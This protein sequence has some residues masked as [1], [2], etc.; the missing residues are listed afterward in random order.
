MGDA[1]MSEKKQKA[2]IVLLRFLVAGSNAVV[3]GDQIHPALSRA[4]RCFA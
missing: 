4:N 1:K 2:S 3:A